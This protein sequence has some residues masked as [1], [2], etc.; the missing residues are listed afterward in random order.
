MHRHVK[1]NDHTRPADLPGMWSPPNTAANRFADFAGWLIIES[2][3]PVMTCGGLKAHPGEAE[4]GLLTAATLTRNAA[5]SLHQLLLATDC[6][7]PSCPVLP[8]T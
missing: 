8:S 4:E 1:W 2:G 7:W 3:P 5:A 6:T